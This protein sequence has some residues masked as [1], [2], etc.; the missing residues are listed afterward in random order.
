MGSHGKFLVFSVIT[1]FLALVLSRLA[2]KGPRSRISDELALR[3]QSFD[4]TVSPTIIPTT[5]ASGTALD[6]KYAPVSPFVEKRKADTTAIILNWSRLQNVILIS[7]ILCGPWLDDVVAEVFIWNNNPNVTLMTK[8]FSDTG[9][10]ANKLRIF[11]SQT[12]ELFQARYL[13]CAQSRTSYCFTQDDDYLVQ[14]DVIKNLHSYFWQNKEVRSVHLLPA[15]EHLL[16]RLRVFTTQGSSIS[17]VFAWLGHGTLLSRSAAR[18]FLDLLRALNVTDDEMK[19]ADNYFTILANSPKTGEIW[20]DHGIEL[21][22]GQPFT[23]GTEGDDRNDRHIARALEYLSLLI[24][25][26]STHRY[27]SKTTPLE[28]VQPVNIA[29]CRM[30]RCLV[31]SNIP[32]LLGTLNVDTHGI[33]MGSVSKRKLHNLDAAERD[34]YIRNPLSYLVDARSDTAFRSLGVAKP[35]DWITLD[36]LRTISTKDQILELSLLADKDKEDMFRREA[37]YSSSVDGT[38]W[39]KMSGTLNCA[40][41]DV[42]TDA[43]IECSMKVEKDARYFRVTVTGPNP[44]H[45]RWGVYELWLRYVEYP[46]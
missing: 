26:A 43:L 15:H 28:S 31:M 2:L 36:A 14:P 40:Q 25:A 16:S 27:V 5:Y 42:Q 11:N 35:E 18:D 30:T 23:V 33:D 7:S 37:S 39:I 17:T 24:S 29:P 12:N 45:E 32:L 41:I 38:E 1:G 22:G 46:S 6:F 20:F 13:A 34:W 8:T 44:L 19:M 3:L 10:S 9:C 21:G 4:I